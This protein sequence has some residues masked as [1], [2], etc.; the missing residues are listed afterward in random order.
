VKDSGVGIPKE[1][2][3]KI[4]NLYYST[5]PDGTGLGLA[6]THQIISQHQGRIDVESTEGKGSQFILTLP[7]A[8]SR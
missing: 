1:H 3:D 5:K 2:L 6:I 4:F 8:D 7:L